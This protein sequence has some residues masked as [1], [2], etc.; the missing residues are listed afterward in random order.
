MV[1]D[2]ER[3]IHIQKNSTRAEI[4]QLKGKY[5]HLI[6]LEERSIAK[7]MSWRL[8]KVCICGRQPKFTRNYSN[9]LT[10]RVIL[11]PSLA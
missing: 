11:Y 2:A 3:R 8:S 6:P 5:Q 9:L 4:F 10:R 7:Q 1:E